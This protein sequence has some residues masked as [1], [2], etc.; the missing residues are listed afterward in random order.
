MVETAGGRDAVVAVVEAGAPADELLRRAIDEAA[1]RSAELLVLQLTDDP[2]VIRRAVAK[3]QLARDVAWWSRDLQGIEVVVA[4]V[5]KVALPDAVPELNE[6]ACV[7]VDAV[8]LSSVPELSCLGRAPEADPDPGART[9]V[10]DG[11]PWPSVVVRP[12]DHQR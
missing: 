2:S 4:A 12:A 9:H 11:H 1:E 6:A 8:L 5:E 10:R 3:A 7:V